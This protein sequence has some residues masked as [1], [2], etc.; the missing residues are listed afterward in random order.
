MNPPDELHRH[1]HGERV[2]QPLVQETFKPRGHADEMNNDQSKNPRS[3]IRILKQISQ[4]RIEKSSNRPASVHGDSSANAAHGSV[5]GNK[6][7]LANMVAGFLLP[8]HF[9]EEGP[10]MIVACASAQKR[11]PVML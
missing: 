3:K 2:D 9:L 8:N 5:R 10:Q 7:R 1:E 11:P 4:K 6:L